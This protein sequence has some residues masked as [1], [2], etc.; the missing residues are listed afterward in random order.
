MSK[1]IIFSVIILLLTAICVTDLFVFLRIKRQR[2]RLNEESTTCREDV[3]RL[4]EV[5]DDLEQELSWFRSL[6]L[7][8]RVPRPRDPD[9]E[10]Q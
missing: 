10:V 5:V 9:P 7:A 6:T 4:K 8:K 3:T 1:D 2:D